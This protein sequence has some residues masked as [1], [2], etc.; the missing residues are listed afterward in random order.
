[1]LW[2]RQLSILDDVIQ[3]MF[4]VE[5]NYNFFSWILILVSCTGKKKCCTGFICSYRL[6]DI[7]AILFRCTR[8]NCN[9]S[10]H[11]LASSGGCNAAGVVSS[12]KGKRMDWN[13]PWCDA[14]A[15]FS[16]PPGT[17]SP[18]KYL[19]VATD[20]NRIGASSSESMPLYICGK[21]YKL[22]TVNELSLL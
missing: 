19:L 6:F 11:R 21:G 16:Q 9:Q 14:N 17:V 13:N 1:M 22:H 5:K 20:V 8:P 4:L 7:T 18:R 15:V 10:V 2:T 3:E 12:A